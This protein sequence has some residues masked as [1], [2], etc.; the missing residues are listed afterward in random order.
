MIKITSLWFPVLTFTPYVLHV[1]AKCN[2][3]IYIFA[4]GNQDFSY[5]LTFLM[6]IRRVWWKS[7]PSWRAIDFSASCFRGC[8]KWDMKFMFFIKVLVNQAIQKDPIDSIFITIPSVV[9][10]V[11]IISNKNLL[12]LAVNNRS[13]GTLGSFN[14]AIHLVFTGPVTS[15]WT[16]YLVFRLTFIAHIAPV[17]KV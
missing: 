5:S 3:F 16:D 8:R 12:G 11:W 7:G 10:S 6:L 1:N 15:D 14:H 2:T 9:Q 13:F 4:F 17:Q